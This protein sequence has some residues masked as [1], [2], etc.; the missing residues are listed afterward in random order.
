M[1]ELTWR[2]KGKGYLKSPDMKPSET[3]K[4]RL[5]LI[6]KH[7][8]FAVIVSED[9]EFG[10]ETQFQDPENYKGTR[11][12]IFMEVDYGELKALAETIL[13]VEAFSRGAAHS[14]VIV[15]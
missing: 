2:V 8:T 10:W 12:E 9:C 5:E 4:L 11:G 7:G 1:E 3:G 15:S 6:D 13:K 14:H